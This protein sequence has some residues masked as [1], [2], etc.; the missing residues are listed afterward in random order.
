[1]K[2]GF[3]HEG[4]RKI[5]V[6]AEVDLVVA[7]WRIHV[8]LPLL[9]PQ[10]KQVVEFTWLAI[11]PIWVK[12]Y[13]ARISTE[14]GSGGKTADST[15][16]LSSFREKFPDSASYKENA[17]RRADRQQRTVP[18]QQLCNECADGPVR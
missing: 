9:L 15:C 3:C 11:C 6:I 12:T 2:G 17:G 4:A 8:L 18:L 1:M 5:P 13:A 7:R 10:R 14:R 16:T